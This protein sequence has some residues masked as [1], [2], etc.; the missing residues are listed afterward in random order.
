M[1][2]DFSG[3]LAAVLAAEFEGWFRNLSSQGAIPRAFTGVTKDGTQVTV[4]LTD[5]PL[6]HIQRRDFLIW[7]CRTHQFVAY[8]YATHVKILD[9][10]NPADAEGIDIYAS[11]DL[12]DVSRALKV[13]RLVAGA[14][15]LQLS[16]DEVFPAGENDCIFFGL[17]RCSDI[18][19]PK[20]D[21]LFRNLWTQI[22]VKSLWRQ[23][24]SSARGGM[25]GLN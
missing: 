3:D 11:S 7:L 20:D 25:Y 1:T 24:A 21:A 23:R 16:H 8:A 5:L 19:A 18:I 4:F 10:D 15:S 2:K 22:K 6:D 17:H 9:E 13:T 14:H 12:Y